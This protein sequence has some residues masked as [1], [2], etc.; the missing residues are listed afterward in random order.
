MASDSF[1]IG[2]IVYTIQLS[3]IKFEPSN[4]NVYKNAKDLLQLVVQKN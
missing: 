2:G 1:A 4:L 3:Y